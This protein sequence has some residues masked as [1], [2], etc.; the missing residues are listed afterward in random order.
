MF[1]SVQMAEFLG[2]NFWMK[3][4]MIFSARL[5]QMTSGL[6]CQGSAALSS[7]RGVHLSL[8]L[9]GFR[10]I[11]SPIP[12]YSIP[13]CT[14]D[15]SLLKEIWILSHATLRAQRL[16]IERSRAVSGIIPIHLACLQFRRTSWW[17]VV[18]CLYLFQLPFTKVV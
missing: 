16:G 2:P 17:M 9:R 13:D 10:T 7:S 8:M 12:F 1:I 18:N 5:Y 3:L 15:R 4:T 14:N 11:E 6:F